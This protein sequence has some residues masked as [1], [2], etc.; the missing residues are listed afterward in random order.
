MFIYHLLLII[1]VL[2]RQVFSNFQANILVCLYLT[3]LDKHNSRLLFDLNEHGNKVL[4]F[5]QVFKGLK[6]PLS[7]C[8]SYQ[9]NRLNTFKVF[10][11]PLL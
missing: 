1:H 8:D 2:K 10:Y 9:T 11:A 5:L 7:W 4:I 3:I 6:Y